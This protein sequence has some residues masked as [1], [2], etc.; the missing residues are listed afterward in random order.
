MLTSCLL[1]EVKENVLSKWEGIAK[2][3]LPAAEEKS[4]QSIRDHLP[5]LVDALCDV[6]ESKT[7][8]SPKEIS[9][10]HGRQRF[11][12][13]DYTLAQVIAEYSLLKNVIYDLTM[14]DSTVDRY[15]FRLI[16]FFFDAAVTAAA[17]EFMSLRETELK[18]SAQRLEESHA[19][20][21]RFAG[22]AAHDLRS[23]AGTIAGYA[24]VLISA[25]QEQPALLKAAN[26]IDRTAHR[27]LHLID[28]LL[29][30]AKMGTSEA[31][32]APFPLLLSVDDALAS[33]EGAIRA[34]E[35]RVHVG[36]MPK[37]FGDPVLMTQLFENL[38]ANSLKYRAADR[39]CEIWIEASVSSDRIHVQVKDN[40]LGFKPELREFIFEPFKRAHENLK[41][42]G[43]GIGLATVQRI[44]KLHGGVISAEG[45]ENEGAIFKMIFPLIPDSSNS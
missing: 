39:R 11:S 38:I 12:F 9:K 44:V 22:V 37:I 10:T 7:F 19:D 5:E 33:S 31:K 16:D 17:S 29:I 21:E 34:V 4:R 42:Q 15:S 8:E 6:I 36:P 28:Q 43:S 14:T 26:V 45:V 30:Y 23:P 2:A 32:L 35:A 13:G 41:I 25:T 24:E 3:K 1:R 18:A 20:L 40:G 27:M